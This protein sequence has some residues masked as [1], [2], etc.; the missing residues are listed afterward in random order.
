MMK[1]RGAQ[2]EDLIAAWLPSQGLTVEKR[3]LR[4]GHLEIDIV[5]RQERVIVIVEVRSR[6][7]SSFT[8]P[9][10]SVNAE[11]RKRL[12]YAAER[13]WNR[14][15][16]NDPRVDRMRFDVASVLYTEQGPLIEYSRAA[17]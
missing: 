16:K 13:L 17:F 4:L 10:S 15:Y 3:N 2:A 1:L 11:K 6:S 9:F 12:R 7:L 8:S 5:A 14:W